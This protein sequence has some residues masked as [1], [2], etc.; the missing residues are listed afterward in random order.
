MKLFSTFVVGFIFYLYLCKIKQKESKSLVLGL[1]KDRI[2]QLM[3]AQ[4]MTQQTFAQ[5]VEISP[6]TLSSIFTGRTKPTLNMVEAIRKKI[7]S[8][9][10]EWLMFGKGTMYQDGDVYEHPTNI[11]PSHPTDLMLDFDQENQMTAVVSPPSP[12]KTTHVDY[13]KNIVSENMSSQERPQRKITEIRV[14]FDDLTYESFVP[15]K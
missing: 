2:R 6:A 3:E 1:M 7:P 12:S 14:F 9:N 5:F 8:V 11:S 10:L 4:R 15:K 13:R